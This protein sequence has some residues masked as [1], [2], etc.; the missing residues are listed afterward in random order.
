MIGRIIEESILNR[1]KSSDKIITIYGPR[2][3]GKTTLLHN[4][5]KSLNL[6]ALYINADEGLYNSVLE[7]RDSNK[8]SSLINGYELVMID[9]AQRIE[10]IGI[11]LKIMHDQFK[12]VKLIVTG[13]SSLD[14][15]NNIAEPLTG[16]YWEYNLFPI[17]MEEIKRVSGEFEAS[18]DKDDLLVYGC[19]PDVYTAKNLKDKKEILYTLAKSYL[20]KDL[21]NLEEI[22]LSKKLNDL[23]KLLSFQ[24]GSE[25]SVHELANQLS[26]S[27]ETVSRY[28][29]LLEKTFVVFRLS[30]FSRNLRKE[31]TK[32]DKIY[33]YDLGIRNTIINN[34]QE[35][36]DR[37][38][39]GQLWENFL[40][41]ERLKYLKY[42][43][44][45]HSR[46]FWRTYTGAELDYI[47]ET[48]GKI[49]GYEFKYSTQQRK[50]KPSRGYQSFVEQYKNSEFS[51]INRENFIN[52][53]S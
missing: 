26:L 8:I 44:L 6:K 17:S 37:N 23:V 33:F 49:Y 35:I 36:N 45:F 22:K 25:V 15:A 20:Y 29:D 41:L 13:S 38:D 46:Y 24:I 47:E 19:Y 16:R 1:L 42:N 50:S 5:S 43:N 12:D 21:F 51:L 7:S 32:K 28:I 27:S 18:R 9:E 2:Q 10:N 31:I 48:D 52:F 30:A 40:V 3:V 39:A 14:L 53:I 34:L 4:I 11:N